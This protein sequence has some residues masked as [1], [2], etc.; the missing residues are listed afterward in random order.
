LLVVSHFLFLPFSTNNNTVYIAAIARTPIGSFNGSLAS[1]TAVQLGSLAV[2]GKKI[3]LL[4][5]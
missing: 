5:G 4:S 2:K 3:K 1:F